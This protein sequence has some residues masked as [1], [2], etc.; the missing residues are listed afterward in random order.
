MVVLLIVEVWVHEW[1][2]VEFSHP[3]APLVQVNEI[4]NVHANGLTQGLRFQ[5]RV[6]A[7]WHGIIFHWQLVQQRSVF[8]S[9]KGTENLCLIRSR[10]YKTEFQHMHVI[11]NVPR[12][13]TW[14]W[15][16]ATRGER[17]EGPFKAYPHRRR[18]NSS[19]NSA[20][21]CEFICKSHF[22][23]SWTNWGMNCN[24]WMNSVWIAPQGT[25]QWFNSWTN[26]QIRP[27]I[28]LRCEW[29]IR[30]AFLWGRRRSRGRE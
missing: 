14:T 19:T 1:R 27:W 9:V 15:I 17:S 24:S 20:T 28:R 18:I 13:H 26:L 5:L 7:H 29:A 11:F 2:C 3:D 10:E 25:M 22:S 16:R 30:Q 12:V 21:W 23:S 8:W 4:L 6:E